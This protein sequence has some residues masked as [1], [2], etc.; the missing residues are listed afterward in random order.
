MHFDVELRGNEAHAPIVAQRAATFGKGSR[1]FRDSVA[2]KTTVAS[3]VPSGMYFAMVGL[4][5]QVH[6]TGVALRPLAD[7]SQEFQCAHDR[8]GQR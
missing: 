3:G 4:N 1:A 6:R 8:C 7:W 5:L 2:S